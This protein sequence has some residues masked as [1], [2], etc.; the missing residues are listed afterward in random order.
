MQALARIAAHLAQLECGR[1]DER[2]EG[3]WPPV[4]RVDA[5]HREVVGLPPVLRSDCER[6]RPALA[7][8]AAERRRQID[9]VERGG[10]LAEIALRG[11]RQRVTQEQPPGAA[12]LERDRSVRSGVLEGAARPGA[13]GTSRRKRPWR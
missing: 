8:G 5:E 10:A 2:N 6:E 3:A 11:R 13:A 4:D 12:P 7:I 1:G 9:D